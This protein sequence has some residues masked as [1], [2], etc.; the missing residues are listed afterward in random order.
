MDSLTRITLMPI[1]SLLIL[2]VGAG[3]SA[4]DRWEAGLL[5]QVSLPPTVLV[6]I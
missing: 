1:V 3:T 2:L 6:L 5:R 4:V